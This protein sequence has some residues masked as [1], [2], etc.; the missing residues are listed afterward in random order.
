MTVSLCCY[1]AMLLC[2]NVVVADIISCDGIVVSFDGDVNAMAIPPLILLMFLPT[3]LHLTVS[4]VSIFIDCGQ[5]PFP[6]A[7]YS[8]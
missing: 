7:I 5:L 4:F 3:I 2:C 1:V 8:F 6:C